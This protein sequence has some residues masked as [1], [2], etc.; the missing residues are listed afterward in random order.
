MPLRDIKIKALNPKV[1]PDGTPISKA[2]KVT[3]EKG[4]YFEVKP[5]GFK[6]W[7]FE[8]RIEG[9]EKLLSVGVYPDISLKKARERHDDLRSQLA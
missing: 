6:L 7:R 8:Y 9:K 5:G 1:K 3:D 4:L 2:C